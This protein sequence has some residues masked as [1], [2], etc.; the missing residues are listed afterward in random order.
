[1]SNTCCARLGG[2]CRRSPRH[3]SGIR[4]ISLFVIALIVSSSQRAPAERLAPVADSWV[5][6]CS[7]SANAN[8]GTDPE[9]RVRTAALWGDVKN[10]RSLLRFDL[11]TVPV[12]GDLVTQATLNLYLFT[13]HWDEPQGRTYHVHRVINAWDETH[14]SWQARDGFQSG[15]PVFWDAYLDG[16]PAYQ[17]GGGDFDPRPSSSAMVP[18]IGEWMTWDVTELTRGWI[19]GDFPNQGLLIK[20]ALEFTSYPG[21][22]TP[23]P[24]AQFRSRDHYDDTLWPF[25]RID[26]LTLTF[27]IDIG[28]DHG[29]SDP[30][31]D[32]N[33]AF[34]PGDLY[35]WKSH[36]VAPPGRDGLH[37]DASIFLADP[38]PD[39]PDSV[40]PPATA[41]PV[42]TGGPA[43]Y[44]SYL[45]LDGHDLLDVS[46]ADGT[47]IPPGSA[48]TSPLP[49][50]ASDCIQEP[51]S[52]FVS[53]DDDGSAGWPAGDVPVTAASP[54]GDRHGGAGHVDEVIGL[55]IREDP[56][57]PTQTVRYRYAVATEA[58]LHLSL[59]ADPT[60]EIDDDDLDSLDVTG[61]RDTCNVWLFSVD[62]EATA[63]LDPGSIY[64]VL[65]GAG[66]IAIVNAAVHLGLPAGTDVDGFEFAWLPEPGSTEPHVL[67]LLFSVDDDDPLTVGID[68]SGGLDPAMIYRSGLTGT[69]ASLLDE[70]L[71]D[72]IDAIGAWTGHVE[73]C[74]H[75]NADVN[76]DGHVDNIDLQAFQDCD[77]GPALPWSATGHPRD[78]TCLDQDDDGDVDQADFGIFQRCYSGPS[79]PADSRCAN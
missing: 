70:A 29:L 1:M 5:N 38:A 7:S 79:E 51:H 48:L 33:E 10:Q 11:A 17:P 46:F 26:Y 55:V 52:L 40:A 44:V 20:D 60:S 62:H 3:C 45:D 61:D 18:A 53:F 25:L 15:Q 22:D 28:S 75:P 36:L 56:S 77:G 32:G 13:Y 78:C 12:T 43:D 74:S 47:L 19:D 35:L 31:A 59:A 76:S 37:D 71:P 14:S 69:S 64:E 73:L 23:S 8:Y 30:N 63:G 50:F 9:L 34:D 58:D 2:T 41:V 65:P 72:D 57:A 39:A 66:P 42:G 68:E 27:S 24:L 67:T 16:Q 21:T 49:R 54:A 6:S 4:T